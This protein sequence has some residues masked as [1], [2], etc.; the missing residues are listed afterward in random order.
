MVN[1]IFNNYLK[2][3]R[4]FFHFIAG[5][6]APL[7]GFLINWNLAIIIT[8]ISFFLLCIFEI[9]RFKYLKINILVINSLS[10]LLKNKE[11]RKIT[12][13]TQLAFTSLLILLLF[14]SQPVI[15]GLALLYISIG[16]PIAAI[17]GIKF[18][19][20]VL[21][22]GSGTI[23][24]PQNGKTIEGTIAFASVALFLAYLIWSKGAYE[25]FFAAA[26]GALA[27]ALVEFLPIPIDDNISVPLISGFVMYF[28]WNFSF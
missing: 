3:D 7:I 25:N 21:F 26:L 11:K 14:Y 6:F 28:F 17:V 19:K 18:G 1:N 8:S 2:W 10:L 27:A 15:G 23:K 24:T 13:A 9:L 20:T 4:H 5:S 22:R 16:D 12:A